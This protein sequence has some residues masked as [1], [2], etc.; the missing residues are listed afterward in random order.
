MKGI[1]ETFCRYLKYKS[2]QNRLLVTES[3]LKTI[4]EQDKQREF[5]YSKYDRK[6]GD[7]KDKEE[8]KKMSS[9]TT[10]S[11]VDNPKEMELK[12]AND[13]ISK[14]KERLDAL[15]LIESL[16]YRAIREL[17]RINKSNIALIQYL[18][19]SFDDTSSS[20]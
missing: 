9:K 16:H 7:A 18:K 20:Y 3:T 2:E 14:G 6:P 13:T 12:D 17:L 4:Q 15:V 8:K 11:F 19:P 10:V 1:N 5:F